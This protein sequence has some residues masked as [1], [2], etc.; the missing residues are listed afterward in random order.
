MNPTLNLGLLLTSFEIIKIINI[1][2]F[3]V[4]Q[5]QIISNSKTKTYE[6]QNSKKC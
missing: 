4:Q 1:I 5:K 3:E 2:R 6:I